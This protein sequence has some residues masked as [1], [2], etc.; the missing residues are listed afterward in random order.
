MNPDDVKTVVCEVVEAFQKAA[1]GDCPP[2]DEKTVPLKSLPEFDSPVSLG[3][4]GKI[5][6]RLGL[7]IPP[8]TNV[9]GD[10]KGLYSIGQTVSILCKLLAEKETKE[11]VQA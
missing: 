3:A 10:K 4:T 7:T 9:F 6:R 5:G 1:A 8:R 11:A 2:L